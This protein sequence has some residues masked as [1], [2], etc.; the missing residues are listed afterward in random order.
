MFVSLLFKKLTLSEE[1]SKILKK[2]FMIAILSGCFE[3][4]KN[5]LNDDCEIYYQC[6]IKTLKL[7]KLKINK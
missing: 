6:S 7:L 5:E 2:G 4:S 3:F 1:H